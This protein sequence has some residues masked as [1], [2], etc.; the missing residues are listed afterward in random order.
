MDKITNTFESITN[1]VEPISRFFGLSESISN[2]TMFIILC[3]VFILLLI[4]LTYYFGGNNILEKGKNMI[5]GQG[6]HDGN[7][8]LEKG[9]NI[10]L[11]Q[12]IHGGNKEVTFTL[13]YVDWCPH[14]KTVKP[15]WKKLESDSELKHININ[16]INCEDNESIAKEKNIEGFPTILLNNNGKEVAYNGARE[17]TDFKKFLQSV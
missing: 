16:K 2:T 15:E 8:F 9:K 5:L 10:I 17:Y 14:C 7:N 13:Y 6:I 4:G 1:S 12:G 3:V 11:G